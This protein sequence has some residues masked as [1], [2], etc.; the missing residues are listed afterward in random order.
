M[1]TTPG[2]RAATSGQQALNDG[3]PSTRV[4]VFGVVFEDL[5][6]V[7]IN[8]SDQPMAIRTI[9]QDQIAPGLCSPEIDHGPT[10]QNRLAGA[11]RV[12]REDPRTS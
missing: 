1:P 6:H 2:S 9:A 4:F 3:R 10:A 5:H 8:A 12:P 11:N 7:G